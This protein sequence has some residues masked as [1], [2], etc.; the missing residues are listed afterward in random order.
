MRGPEKMSEKVRLLRCLPC[1]FCFDF[2]IAAEAK[3]FCDRVN[4]DREQTPHLR[5]PSVGENLRRK[6]ERKEEE[7]GYAHAHAMFSQCVLLEMLAADG[8]A[9][10]RS[11]IET[12]HGA[13]DQWK[14][15][16][17]GQFLR[18]F[19]LFHKTCSTTDVCNVY[20]TPLK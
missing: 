7:R 10:P 1:V 6:K 11:L 5:D 13:T 20:R 3:D 8:A 17:V 18:F 14:K 19:G 15:G 12:D 9:K 4:V 16:K 2:P